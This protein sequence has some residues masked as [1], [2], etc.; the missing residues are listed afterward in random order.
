MRNISE[1]LEENALDIRNY[2]NESVKYYTPKQAIKLLKANLAQISDEEDRA[3]AVYN[4]LD[5]S[6]TNL[7]WEGNKILV[8][9]YDDS[10]NY[11]LTD[12]Q[13]DK[14]VEKFETMLSKIFDESSELEELYHKGKDLK[15]QRE[16]IEKQ[17][18]KELEK[19]EKTKLYKE[20][21]SKYKGLHDYVKLYTLYYAWRDNNLW[22][23]I[24]RDENIF[25]YINDCLKASEP[26]LKIEDLEKD[27]AYIIVDGQP[28]M[29]TGD[30][31]PNSRYDI[32]LAGSV[33]KYVGNGAFDTVACLTNYG[34]KHVE[35][36]RKQIN[37]KLDQ[38]CIFAEFDSFV[39]E[40]SKKSKA[41][42]SKV[43]EDIKKQQEY[44]KQVDSDTKYSSIILRLIDED[45]F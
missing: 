12:K 40:F 28:N 31:S 33:L 1:Y 3:I 9:S 6:V 5:Y 34:F 14:R 11:G 23:V 7:D 45:T 13:Y 10:D 4:S 35:W 30:V 27:K 25:T 36:D 15:K 16:E 24:P 17:K 41:L 8:K 38:D 21:A 20:I 32:I 29:Y 19:L 26:K 37:K 39:K 2:F 22:T 43:V 44:F 18:I 42:E